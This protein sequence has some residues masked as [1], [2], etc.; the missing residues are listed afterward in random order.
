[1]G[2]YWRYTISFDRNEDVI[3]KAL[4]VIEEVFGLHQLT[5]AYP[6]IIDIDEDA[7]SVELSELT[8]SIAVKLAEALP[9]L[10][11]S[12][13]GV[14]DTSEEAGEYMDFLIEYRD[15][16][17]TEKSSDWYVILHADDYE[18]YDD[19]CEAYC[20]DDGEPRF[21][22][23]AYEAFQTGEWYLLDSGYGDAVQQVP[24]YN[25]SQRKL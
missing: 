17:L 3:T 22:E 4:P 7:S 6:F 20:D 1:M 12:M 24:L 16:V 11:F 10:G 2:C 9:E 13:K 5:G 23:E 15:G 19:F 8:K 14:I 21:S 18:D 25:V